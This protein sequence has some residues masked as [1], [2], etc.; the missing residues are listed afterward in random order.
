MHSM[1]AEILLL[2]MPS[3]ESKTFTLIAVAHIQRHSREN[4]VKNIMD[5]GDVTV[6]VPRRTYLDV[7]LGLIH[8]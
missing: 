2:Y 4:L 3:T 5:T 7:A 6:S 8:A 1:L